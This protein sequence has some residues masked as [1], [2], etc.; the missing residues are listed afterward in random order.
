MQTY[1]NA[2]AVSS[3][4]KVCDFE[5]HCLFYSMKQALRV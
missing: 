4:L 1:T 5:I 2:E 3:S